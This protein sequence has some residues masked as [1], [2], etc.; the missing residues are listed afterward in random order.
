[1]DFI[2]EN[3]TLIRYQGNEQEVFVPADVRKLGFACFANCRT[4]KIVHLCDVRHI[5][6]FAFYGCEDL[7][8]V[9]LYGKKLRFIGHGAFLKCKNLAEA[10]LNDSIRYI[11]A[12]AF[13]KCE[14]LIILRIPISL[15][16][17]EARTFADCT[18]LG[19][20]IVPDSVESIGSCAFEN[21]K[22]LK[23]L[24]LPELFEV[25]MLSDNE[26]KISRFV[27]QN[28]YS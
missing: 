27:W 12:S 8:D 24:K 4:V 13:E 20:V 28:I 2:I 3:K 21:C 26:K 11:G 10:S 9:N 22:N 18:S 14:S 6:H 19:N 1:M 25:S 23:N 16:K 17:I 5:S 7:R 15:K